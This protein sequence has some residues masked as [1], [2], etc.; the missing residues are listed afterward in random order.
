MGNE[1]LYTCEKCGKPTNNKQII[2]MTYVEDL[3]IHR[4]NECMDRL[5]AE[6]EWEN[7]QFREDDIV[8]P[9]CN[10]RFSDYEEKIQMVDDPYEAQ[11]DLIVTCPDCGERF[12]LEIETKVMY[13]TKKCSEDFDYEKYKKGTL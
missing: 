1:Y 12:A 3:V 2:P 13:T 10:S 5:H 9:W 7:E 4:C 6:I 8:C 11:E